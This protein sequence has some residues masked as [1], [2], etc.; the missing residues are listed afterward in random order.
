MRNKADNTIDGFGRDLETQFDNE[1]YI[2]SVNL[3]YS[4]LRW[5]KYKNEQTVYYLH[6]T[7]QVLKPS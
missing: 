1:Q 2:T 4:E 5:G 6:G 7:F 3:E